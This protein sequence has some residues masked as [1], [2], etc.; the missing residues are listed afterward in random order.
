MNDIWS[1]PCCTYDNVSTVS[2]CIICGTLNYKVAL[3]KEKASY[4]SRAQPPSYSSYSS[5]PQPRSPPRPQYQ[6]QPQQPQKAKPTG[7]EQLDAIEFEVNKILGDFEEWQKSPE[8]TGPAFDLEKY[9]KRIKVTS[10]LLFQQQLKLDGVSCNGDE[11][12]RERRKKLTKFI[13]EKV[14]FLDSCISGK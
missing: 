2:E 13:I 14:G 1:C 10:E 6:P 12:L 5:Q 7:A 9:V 11:G 8:L 3:K 4:A